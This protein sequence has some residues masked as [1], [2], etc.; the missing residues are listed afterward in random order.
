LQNSTDAQILNNLE[1]DLKKKQ[2]LLNDT[3]DLLGA[4]DIK[5]LSDIEALLKG[6]T[7]K[8][9]IHNQETK[10][11]NRNQEINKLAQQLDKTKEKLQ[12]YADNLKTKES[13]IGEYQQELKTKDQNLTTL[14]NQKNQLEKA[15]EKRETELSQ[16]LSLTQA[17]IKDLETNLLNLSK[18]KLTN[19]KQAKALVEQLETE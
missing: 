18:Q 5:S 1:Q 7:L 3:I 8:E 9:L 19:Q 16:N 6:K 17:K 4:E 14:Q 15:K 12:F 11:A 13:I 2:E 10:I